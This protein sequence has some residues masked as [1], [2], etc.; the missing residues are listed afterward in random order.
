[1]QNC[2]CSVLDLKQ[3]SRPA[4]LKDQCLCV[5]AAKRCLRQRRSGWRG[6]HHNRLRNSKQTRNLL[7]L[8]F[9]ISG[10]EITFMAQA[11]LRFCFAGTSASEIP[12]ELYLG[13]NLAGD[14][15]GLT[16]NSPY[17]SIKQK[18]NSRIAPVSST[19]PRRSAPESTSSTGP[20]IAQ[21]SR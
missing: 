18:I 21:T 14:W 5:D 11:S 13:L 17:I 15:S 10:T 19:S 16:T 8:Q 1:M 12:R 2:N 20:G 7:L 4:G 3:G 9:R 6:I